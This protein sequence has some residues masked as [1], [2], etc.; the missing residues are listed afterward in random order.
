MRERQKKFASHVSVN[1]DPRKLPFAPSLTH[2]RSRRR[3]PTMPIPAMASRALL[4][5]LAPRTYGRP[6][7]TLCL[8]LATSNPARSFTSSRASWAASTGPPASKPMSIPGAS[9]AARKTGAS[10]AVTREDI[11]AEML[12]ASSGS[13]GSVPASAPRTAA[14]Q[15]TAAA[16][17]QGTNPFSGAEE[18]SSVTGT[19]G[20]GQTDW[21]RSYHGLSTQPFPKEVADVLLE[22]IDTHDVEIKPGASVV[23]SRLC[24]LVLTCSCRPLQTVSSTCPRSSTAAF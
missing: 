5:R 7:P 24:P 4:Q 19:L 3:P 12:A 6:T 11:D 10:A 18:A 1:T 14:P 20:E 17:P 8:C 16:V 9:A 23:V 22:P 15:A 21:S 13:V 2:L